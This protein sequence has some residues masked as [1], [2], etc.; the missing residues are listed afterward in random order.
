MRLTYV[1]P[2]F[3]PAWG[4]GGPPRLTFDL[5]RQLA[6]AGHAVHVLTTDA[7]DG[8]SRARPS[9]ETMAGITVQRLPNVS[10]RLAW[11]Y[12]LFFPRGFRSALQAA[13]ATSDMVHLFDFRDYQNAVALPFLERSGVPFV[14]S[15]LGELPRATG[16]K[17]PIKYVYDLLVGYRLLRRAAALLA[18]TPEEAEWYARLGGRA[19]RIHVLPLAVAL[20]SLP[21]ATAPGTFRR[22]HGLEASHRVVLFLGRIHEYKGLDVLLRAF[23]KMR[24]HRDEV[25][26][27]IAG[28][29][30]GYL[31]TA[32][33]M[34][35]ELTPPGS[36]IFSGPVYGD[37]RFAAYRDADLFAITPSHAEQT[38]LAALEAAACGT[39]VLT[40]VHAPIPGLDAAGA[41]LTVAYDVAAVHEAMVKLLDADSASA[42]ARA[43]CLVRERF[44]LTS[45]S[46][47]LETLYRQA[48]S[49]PK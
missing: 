3:A 46:Q 4:Y 5:A 28:R 34:A 29:D 26:L 7:L 1:I 11:E 25:R 27:V 23:A 44:S 2:Y 13:L 10:N 30:D 22:K 40:T 9:F 20:D 21:V 35:A 45:V 48:M 12:K 49:A 14:L 37:D 39:P 36:V 24:R 15:A 17:R 47:Q 33:R 19:D 32:D 38:S 41:G 42:G 8:S 6:R 43:A 16:P 18:Q 31:D